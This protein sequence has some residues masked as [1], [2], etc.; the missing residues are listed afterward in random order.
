MFTLIILII[1]SRP[2]PLTGYRPQRN[3]LP[4]FSD[5]FSWENLFMPF[6]PF[7]STKFVVGLV[8]CVPWIKQEGHRLW[9][10]HTLVFVNHT[11]SF[12]DDLFLY[13]LPISQPIFNNCHLFNHLSLPHLSP[14]WKML[15]WYQALV[16]GNLLP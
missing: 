5:Y 14:N 9:K 11:D 12:T 2:Q 7:I 4:I 16:L 15:V 8:K 10:S 6:F 1:A 3:V 13:E